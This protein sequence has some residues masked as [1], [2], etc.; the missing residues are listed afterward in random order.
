MAPIPIKTVHN[1]TYPAISPTRPELSTKGK[2]ALITG[3]GSGIGAAIAK[4]FA[5]SDI[6]DLAL[7]GR[8][9]KTLLE[10]K[11]E[12]ESLY[13]E[14][15]VW[16]YR[17]DIVD[18][19]STLSAVQSF[20]KSTKGSI[21]IVVANAGYMPKTNSIADSDPDDWWL[22]FDISVRG[23]FNLLQA[24]T[25]LAAPNA[26]VIHVS[27]EAM[28]M[29]YM[30]GFSGYRAS[31]LAAYKV[32]EYY[33][34]ENPDKTVI[35]FHPG[36]IADTGM[37]KPIA[38]FIDAFGLVPDDVTLAGDFSVWAASE[39]AKFLS[40]RFVW[41]GW[42]IDELKGLKGELEKD[43]RKFTIGLLS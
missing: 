40:G 8:T 11:A 28:Y 26:S 24:F 3:G 38:G 36:L 20:A 19:E 37:T 6:S 14:T 4:S 7:L 35:Q 17:V 29:Q 30:E 5:K 25:P 42:D 12:I 18:R 27:T 23:N 1:T 31:K 9:E 41:A 15:T 16:T 32:F 13:P 39:E 2:N 22:G 21:D 34:K 10:N 33:A 43:D